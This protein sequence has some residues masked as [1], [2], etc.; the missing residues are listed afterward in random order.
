M[1]WPFCVQSA[2]DIPQFT[3]TF[4]T[5]DTSFGLTLLLNCTYGLQFSGYPEL[6]AF[7]SRE[8]SK[9]LVTFFFGKSAFPDIP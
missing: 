8:R 3:E 6:R 5:E 2:L 4:R 9:W 7:G 1:S